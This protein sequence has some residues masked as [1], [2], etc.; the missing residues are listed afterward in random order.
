MDSLRWRRWIE[1][2]SKNC[3]VLGLDLV[4][5]IFDTYAM[6]VEIGP[7]VGVRKF[8]VVHRR[9]HACRVLFVGTDNSDDVGKCKWKVGRMRVHSN[10]TLHAATSDLRIDLDPSSDSE[11]STWGRSERI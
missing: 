9:R 7:L 5:R 1:A 3:Q 6:Y 4:R 8:F 11:S 10:G 2:P